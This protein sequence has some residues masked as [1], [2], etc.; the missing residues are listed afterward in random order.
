MLLLVE[1]VLS[2]G[3]IVEQLCPRLEYVFLFLFFHRKKL[4]AGPYFVWAKA[5]ISIPHCVQSKYL[6]FF[7]IAF[8]IALSLD[9]LHCSQW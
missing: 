3:C 1:L 2:S 7:F 9:G 4:F 8:F 6:I 5:I